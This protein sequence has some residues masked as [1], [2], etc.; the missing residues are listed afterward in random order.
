LIGISCPAFSIREFWDVAEE[1]LPHFRLWEIVA[2]AD[3]FLPD[4]KDDVKELLAS[5]ELKVSIHAPFSDINIAAFDE[6]TRRYSVNMLRDVF[7]IASDLGIGVVTIHP[8]SI[9]VIQSYDKPRVSKLTRRS[10][11]EISAHA[12]EYSTVIAL[13]NMPDMRFAICKTAEEMQAMLEGL[14][15]KMC[16]D[17]AHANTTSQIDKMLRLKSL[18][19]NVHVHDNGGKRDEHLTLGTGNINFKAIIKTLEGYRGDYVI[20]S[21]SLESALASKEYLGKL[22]GQ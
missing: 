10:L 18:F 7:E 3:H 12:N 4:I 20:E 17:I 9:L 15:L 6:R 16:F 22:L 14:D 2:D 11:E 13:E 1:L 21:M 5:T 19:A 8:G